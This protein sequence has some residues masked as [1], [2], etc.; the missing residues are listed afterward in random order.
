VLALVFALLARTENP[1][2]LLA[3][4]ALTFGFWIFVVTQWITL[5]PTVI[6]GFVW[7]GLKA[8][9]S[10]MNVAEFTNPSAIAGLGMFATE[11]IWAHIRDYGWNFWKHAVDILVCAVLGFM[12]LACFFWIAIEVFIYFLQ[13]YLFAVLATVLMPFGIN[14][15]T[16]WIADGCFATLLAHGIKVM[17]LAM[18]TSAVFPLLRTFV[19]A[20]NPTWGQ[21]FGMALGMGAMTFLCVRAPSAAVAM[22]T[23]GPQL[24]AGVF[25]ASMIGAAFATHAIGGMASSGVR[26]WAQ[27]AS[28]DSPPQRSGSGGPPPGNVRPQTP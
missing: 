13:F 17:V 9:G 23:R 18:V 7:V 12:I 25:A 14:R 6:N 2:S 27:W 16:S 26:K 28:K 4:K 19:V 10:R 11:P 8:G 22:F 21:L 24:S 5:A 3:Q 15:A 20:P 1:W